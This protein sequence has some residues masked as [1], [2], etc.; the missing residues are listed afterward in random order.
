MPLLSNS[1]KILSV[2]SAFPPSSFT[3][4]EMR[5]LLDVTNPVVHRLLSAPHIQKRHLMVPSRKS[6]MDTCDG[7]YSASANCSVGPATDGDASTT[8]DASDKLHQSLSPL[9]LAQTDFITSPSCGGALFNNESRRALSL[10]HLEGLSTIGVEA[11]RSAIEAAG[12]SDLSQVAVVVAVTSTGLA[13]PGFS[14]ILMD[15]LNLSPNCLRT[16][17]VGMGCNAG[18]SGLRTLSMMLSGLGGGGGGAP[19]YGLLVC[20]EICSAAYVNDDTTGSGIVNSLFGDGAAAV[21]LGVNTS[22]PS[23]PEDIRSSV[24]HPQK[25][26]SDLRSVVELPHSSLT[27]RGL[28]GI[29]LLDFESCTLSEFADDMRYEVSAVHDRLAFL[30]SKRIPYAVGDN[31]AVPVLALLKRHRLTPLDIQHWVVHSGGAAVI[32][33]VQ[34]NL[35]LPADALRHTVSVLRDYGNISSGSFLVSLERL[36]EEREADIQR[37]HL[38]V[39]IA[40]GPGATIEVGLGRVM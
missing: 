40:M 21:V 32:E 2:Q 7:S 20:C 14:A 34:R 25:I 1:P 8:F 18:M 37:G 5:N 17:V 24:L 33:G 6:S 15:K 22:T 19:C 39:F 26:C 4:D 13:M 28:E 10:R 3:Q 36:L 27:A 38:V 30:L 31:V 11:A 35:G 16:D 12:V 9:S 29:S 23:N